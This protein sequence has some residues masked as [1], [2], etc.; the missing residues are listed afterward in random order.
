MLDNSGRRWKAARGFGAEIPNSGNHSAGIRTSKS[1]SA[2]GTNSYRSNAT[3][4][5]GS[6][7]DLRIHPP[8]Q[9][10]L[11]NRGTAGLD[12]IADEHVDLPRQTEVPDSLGPSPSKRPVQELMSGVSHWCLGKTAR[13]AECELHRVTR[14]RVCGKHTRSRRGR[15]QLTDRSG[16]RSRR[17]GRHD[18][19][20]EEHEHECEPFPARQPDDPHRTPHTVHETEPGRAWVSV[21]K[22]RAA[23]P[24][25][26]AG[27]SVAESS[28]I[29]IDV[30]GCQPLFPTR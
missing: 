18:G 23:T 3:C 21:H 12:S 24:P 19:E 5:V 17:N 15:T 4:L 11:A 6:N 28:A 20:C 30:N 29:P 22:T 2:L 7:P 26:P 13:R 10:S 14:R 1:L 16:Q 9:S 25:A 8:D 27:A